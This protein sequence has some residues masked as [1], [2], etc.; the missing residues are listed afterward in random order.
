VSLY[1]DAS[2]VLPTLVDEGASAAVLRFIREAEEPLVLGDFTAVEVASGIARLVRMSVLTGDLATFRLGEFDAWRIGSTSE[3]VI[4]T[5]DIRLSGV[6]A[7]R[8]ALGLRAPD[9]LHAAVCLRAGLTLVTLDQKL[10]DAARA[11]GVRV[12]IPA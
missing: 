11:L 1:L 8:F 9:A 5:V 10:A 3:I 4:Q 12:E 2:V 7:R 6:L